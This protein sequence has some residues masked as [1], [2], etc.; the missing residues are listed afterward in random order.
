MT[1]TTETAR[2]WRVPRKRPDALLVSFDYH[3]A[4]HPCDYC[5]A[6]SPNHA[7]CAACGAPREWERE[8]Q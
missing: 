4:A 7:P 1:R 6:K 5:G 2:V 3:P 8:T